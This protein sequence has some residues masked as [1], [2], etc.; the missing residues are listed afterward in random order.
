MQKNSFITNLKFSFS[1]LRKDGFK[2]FFGYAFLHIVLGVLVPLLFAVF[3]SYVV[4]VMR[5][6]QVEVE[7]GKLLGFLI[8]ILLLQMIDTYALHLYE[9]MLFLF[10]N[11]QGKR[12]IKKAL[13]LPYDLCESQEGQKQFEKARRAVYEGNENGIEMFLKQFVEVCVNLLGLITYAALI[14]NTNYFFVLILI[15]FT[16]TI[17]F[18]SML[19]SKKDFFVQDQLSAEYTRLQ[20]MYHASLE[21]KGAKDIR[22]YRMQEWFTEEF[23]SLRTKICKLQKKSASYYL[24][25]NH[26]EKLLAFVRDVIVYGAFI[27]FMHRGTMTIEQFILNLGIVAGFNG[28]ILHLFD[29]MKELIRNHTLVTYFYVFLQYGEEKC[30]G[31]ELV[32]NAL[33]SHTLTME[34]VCF[35]YPGAEKDCIHDLDLTIQSGE[36]LALVGI[37]GAGKTTIVKLLLGL[38]KPTGGRILL[39]GTDIRC[40][41][42][43]SYLQEFSVAFQEIFVFAATIAENV[44]GLPEAEQNREKL[45]EKLELAGLGERISNL[46][47]K[48]RTKLTKVLDPQGIELSGGELQ[49][50][51]LARTL[52]KE[53]SVMILDEPTAALD[54]IAENEL[55]RQYHLLTEGK[56]GIYISHR[57]SSTRFCD[58]IVFWEQ[59]RIAELGTY[60]EL[61]EQHG[62]YAE[63]YEIQAKYYKEG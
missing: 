31:G 15:V 26:L 4:G 52:Y 22:I 55:Y 27:Y 9:Q 57:L 37:N 60:Q 13:E 10:R 46:P 2:G 38:Y 54:P 50:L 6:R 28:W 61:M 62:K 43:K 63:M 41:D 21:Q 58:R 51:L 56:T 14:G 5:G 8:V 24:I 33:S 29:N 45:K 7:I 40:F 18:A 59:G 39:D 11:Q 16:V 44:T 23:N 1:L 48:E 20:S 34:R 49:K 25:F 30:T 53:S 12:L 32:P 35:R 17:I 47:E 19:T 42:Q 36:K 3:P